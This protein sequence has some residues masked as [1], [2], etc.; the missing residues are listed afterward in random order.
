[1]R[2]DATSRLVEGTMDRYLLFDNGCQAYRD[3]AAEVEEA[4]D[5][6]LRTRSLHDPQ[7]QAL[8][9]RARPGWRWEPTLLIVDGESLRAYTGAALVGCLVTGIGP[10]R[11]ARIARLTERAA[12]QRLGDNRRRFLRISGGAVA[13]LAIEPRLAKSDPAAASPGAS[14]SVVNHAV[15]TTDLPHTGAGN[16]LIN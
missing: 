10:R 2:I 3:L 9:D 5:S 6:W 7:M 11:A 4:A 14:G 15:A 13:S 1:V 12:R 8:L 16:S